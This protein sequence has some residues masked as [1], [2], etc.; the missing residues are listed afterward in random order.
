MSYSLKEAIRQSLL[1]NTPLAALIGTRVTSAFAPHTTAADGPWI[2]MTQISGQEDGSLSGDA[3]LTRPRFQ[4][5]IGGPDQEEVDAVRD[6]LIVQ[7]HASTKTYTDSGAVDRDITFFHA[8]DNEAWEESP[9]SYKV[10]V[11]FFIWANR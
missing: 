8:D 9:R 7:F 11:D 1:A 4:F 6:T 5:T 3:G 2:V 10:L